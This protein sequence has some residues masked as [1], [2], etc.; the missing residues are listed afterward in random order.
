MSMIRFDCD[1]PALA[2]QL[3]VDADLIKRKIAL[4]VHSEIVST[5]P[6]DT[7]RARASWGMQAETP[8]YSFVAPAGQ[9]SYPLP[10]IEP[11][12]GAD[13]ICI[14]NNLEYII[15]LNEGH[16]QQAPEMFVEIAVQK[17]INS[18]KG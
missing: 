4:D 12:V 18:V 15:P 14:F 17:V 8:D 3:Q 16:S 11:P 1:I 7:G 6:V 10:D 13:K 9:E 5:T 2:R